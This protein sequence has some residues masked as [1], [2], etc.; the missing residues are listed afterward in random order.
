MSKRPKQVVEKSLKAIVGRGY[1]QFWR[2][3]KRYRVVKGSRGS[4]KSATTS[5]NIIYRMMKYPLANTLVVRQTYSSLAD[6]CFAQLKWA[7]HRLG[8]D[9][10]WQIKVSPLMMIYIPTGQRILFRG[11]DDP[12]KTTSVT[13]ATGVLCWGWLEEAY[14]V[15]DEASF[16][17]IDESLRGEMPPGYFIQW[18][19]T[20][21]PWDSSSWLKSR[22]FDIPHD[23]VLAMTTNYTCNEWLT[24][25]DLTLFDEMK[26][27]DPERYKVA[28]LG[29]WG[30]A[31][32]QY[33]NQWRSDLH[34]VDPFAVPKSW[35]RFR[36]MDWGQARPYCVLWFA[37]DYDGNLWCYRELYG[38]G[39]K[40]NV[41]TGETAEEVAMRIVKAETVSENVSYG[42]L[43]NACWAR[44]GVTGPTIAEAINTILCDHH[45]VTFGECS[46]GR[47]EGGNAIK[48][49]LIGTKNK[50]GEQ[51]PALRFFS[52]CIHTIRTMPQLAHDKNNPELYDTKGEDHAADTI[53]Y[54][55]M[56][57][58]WTP[59]KPHP[60]AQHDRYQHDD[61]SS[62]WAV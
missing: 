20:F 41:G 1:N 33:F 43:D 57:R 25:E 32:G 61:C 3:K 42:V 40:P 11:L 30:V 51:V 15:K 28:G 54:A 26:E 19:L 13:V 62:V 29:D 58:P 5:L 37:V 59:T 31:A 8:V 16:A 56:S 4:K 6:S 47:V 23:N 46:K 60:A 44:T 27:L 24:K 9:H 52:T 14:E 38:W 10:L 21:N 34:V 22:F 17:T 50:Q 39:G 45:L 12:L 36:A 7:I 2:C 53:A 35:M 55:C 48:Q 49:R 18:T